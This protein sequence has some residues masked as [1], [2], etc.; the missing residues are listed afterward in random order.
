MQNLVKPL[1]FVL[2]ILVVGP[3]V[4]SQDSSGGSIVTV[5]DFFDE[6][7]ARYADIEDYVASITITRGDNVQSGT[8]Y[9]RRPNQ[10]MVE[11]DSPENQ[12]MV[13]DGE[14]LQVYIPLYNVVLEQELRAESSGAGAAGAGLA[15]EEGLALLRRNYSPSFSTGPGPVNLDESSDEQVVKLLLQWRST[16]EGYRQLEIAVNE[17]LLIR[18]IA[19]TTVSREE[20]VFDFTSIRV[21]QNIPEGQFDYEAD[22]SAN[23]IR[24][25]LYG[26]EG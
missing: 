6:L 7:A 23:V 15:S 21:N 13:S 17:N 10:I 25:F 16:A 5:E 20:I 8:I 11:F 26:G 18:R 3:Q 22:P 24:D 9:Y 2:L 19:G 4:P 12:V 14:V 1:L